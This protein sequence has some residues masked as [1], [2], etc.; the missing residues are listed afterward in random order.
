MLP[1]FIFYDRK[2]LTFCCL[3]LFLCYVLKPRVGDNNMEYCVQKH[4]PRLFAESV[5]LRVGI[6]PTVQVKQKSRT[7][8]QSLGSRPA[9]FNSS[10]HPCDLRCTKASVFRESTAQ[11]QLTPW[12]MFW[13]NNLLGICVLSGIYIIKDSSLKIG[14]VGSGDIF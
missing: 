5:Q 7:K 9:Y 13:T 12:G 14:Y 4:Q 10:Q 3:D 11:I 1:T 2:L 8:R 6:K